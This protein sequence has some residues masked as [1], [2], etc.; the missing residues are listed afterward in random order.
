MRY[1]RKA[2]I[3]M[4]TYVQQWFHVIENMKN[5]NTYK[6]AWGK[7]ILDIIAKKQL[8]KI[9]FSSI[10]E[11]MLRYYWNQIYFF[12]LKQGPTNQTPT[13]FKIINEMISHY[14]D[15][16]GTK[17]PVWFNIAQSKLVKNKKYYNHQIK[18][19]M[20]VLHQDVSWRFL[21]V[22]GAQIPI[23][24]ID[25]RMNA[26]L[27]CKDALVSLSDYGK[28]LSQFIYFKWSQLLEKF[29]HAPKIANKINGSGQQ[30][31]RRRSLSAYKE[32]LLKLYDKSPIRDFYTDE[33]LSKDDLSV[34]HFI[35]WS[36]IY[37]DDIWNLV[38]TSKSNNSKKSNHL[39]SKEYLSKLIKQNNELIQLIEDNRIKLVIIE[40]LNNQYIEKFYFD[41]TN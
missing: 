17:Q 36:Y 1:S 9:P 39:Y 11:E 41:F 22:G 14:Q 3:Q 40:A 16:V 7:A 21:I 37:S 32:I 26:I 18:K 5:T 10:A 6:L 19:I 12:N 20:V 13:L 2:E 28:L 31:I 38:L 25:K 23:Y 27:L 29:N 4:N 33:I 30:E 8:T 35:P 34:D 15:L 24:S